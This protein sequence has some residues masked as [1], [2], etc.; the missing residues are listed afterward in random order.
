MTVMFQ[1]NRVVFALKTHQPR[2]KVFTFWELALHHLA[3]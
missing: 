2:E 1:S 3:V